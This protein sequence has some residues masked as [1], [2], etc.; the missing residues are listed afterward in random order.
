MPLQLPPSG[1]ASNFSHTCISLWQKVTFHEM[2]KNKDYKIGVC[3][4]S[5]KHAALKSKNKGLLAQNQD[6]VFVW[7]DMSSFGKYIYH[8]CKPKYH[9]QGIQTCKIVINF[10]INTNLNLMKFSKTICWFSAK[11][12][13]LKSKNKGLLAQN[14]DNVF[15]WSD[16]SSC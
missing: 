11:H 9:L 1:W 3:W 2:I 8:I 12:A 5:A 13:A 6:N 4:F 7:S 14:Q 16:M 15:V 10:L